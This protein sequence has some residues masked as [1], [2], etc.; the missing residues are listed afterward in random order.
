MNEPKHKTSI[1]DPDDRNREHV[2]KGD[3]RASD[4][5]RVRAARADW[6]AQ[7]Q[8]PADRREA[9]A[10]A[11]GRWDREAADIRRYA[12]TIERYEPAPM[13]IQLTPYE[14]AE[15]RRL[16]GI[17]PKCRDSSNRETTSRTNATRGDRYCH[18][19][20]RRWLENDA[21]EPTATWL[22]CRS[23]TCRDCR[24]RIDQSDAERITYGLR[25]GDVWL[26][27]VSIDRWRT[28]KTR[29]DRHGATVARFH[30]PRDY[31]TVLVVAD[32][33][34]A[35]GAVKLSEV[36]TVIG[37]LMRTRPTG[38][39]RRLTTTGDIPSRDEWDDRHHKPQTVGAWDWMSKHTQPADIER[40]AAA[41]G[42]PV[43][44]TAGTVRLKV[45]WD[46][47]RAQAVRRW[48]KNPTGKQWEDMRIETLIREGVIEADE[49]PDL[50]VAS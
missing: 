37:D 11:I 7:L 30:S 25:G 43:E 3:Y 26:S 19:A 10:E 2:A 46:D 32:E 5:A 8:L 23:R 15:T 16:L 35:P 50:E 33:P 24:P 4:L 49:P 36:E 45:G 34:V 48:A 14:Q 29:L 41:L 40:V 20:Y 17:P 22:P 21:G 1:S 44:R 27:E 28:V 6:E 39:H 38:Q 18:R 12:F 31:D 9:V 47:W 42:V 13:A